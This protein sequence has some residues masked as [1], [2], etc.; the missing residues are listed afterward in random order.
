M[1]G[2][3]RKKGL[4]VVIKKIGKREKRGL[5]DEREANDLQGTTS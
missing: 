2:W 5:K 1:S 3:H 4:V